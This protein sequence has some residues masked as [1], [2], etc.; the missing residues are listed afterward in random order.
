[1]SKSFLMIERGLAGEQVYHLQSRLTIGRAPE[2]DIHLPDP[3]VS[4]QHALVYIDDEKAILEDI[5]SRNGTYVN[6]EP[7]RKAV[8][9]KGDVVRIGNVTIRFVD[10]GE[11]S[12]QLTTKK[13]QEVNGWSGHDADMNDTLL[14]RSE[15]LQ[16][17]VSDLLL[18]SS[19]K[20]HDLDLVC[21]VAKLFVYNPGQPIIRHGDWGDSL[22]IVLEGKIRVFTYDYQGKDITLQL[23]GENSF[24][25]EGPLLTK[26]PHTST[27]EAME[28]TLLCKLSFETIRDLA[29]RYPIIN[30]LL[31]QNQK[32]HLTCVERRRKSVG[33]E[34][35]KHPRYEIP[36]TII[37]S[38]SP[39][40]NLSDQ[41]QRKIFQGISA[42]ISLSGVRVWLK[43]K[44]LGL[45]PIGCNVRLE[46]VLPSPWQSIRCI[47][48][49]RHMMEANKGDDR[50]DMGIEFSDMSSATQKMLQNFLYSRVT[51][52]A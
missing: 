32:E 25:G 49:V 48:I 9:A 23:L 10:E 18:F 36:L 45:L 51:A 5:G 37:F 31:E 52:E 12:R 28:E 40:F 29:E 4:R 11:P 24:F 38:V 27:F 22:Y 39:E 1:M 8:L 3:S 44:S 47:G 15:R 19:L 41:L 6:E 35:R 26:R 33:L 46:I 2:S 43:D 42:A 30:G 20:Q 17:F 21:Q 34:R 50:A 16:K 14:Q 13:T 7:V